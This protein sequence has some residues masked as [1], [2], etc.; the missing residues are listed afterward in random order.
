MSDLMREQFEAWAATNAF[1]GLSESCME[2]H[3]E[4]YLG[5]E[6]HAAWE[7][8]LASRECM[9]IDTRPIRI[10]ADCH[11]ESGVESV[12]YAA[13]DAIHAAGVKTK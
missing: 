11:V 1:L 7:A 6:L 8:W 5:C 13:I 3:N 2:R 9:V 12:F 4:G 10:E